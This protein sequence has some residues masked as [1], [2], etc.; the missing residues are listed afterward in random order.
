MNPRGGASPQPDAGRDPDRE[1]AS[2]PE[3]DTDAEPADAGRDA[4]RSGSEKPGVRYEPL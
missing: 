2:A 1:L 3:P 4:Q